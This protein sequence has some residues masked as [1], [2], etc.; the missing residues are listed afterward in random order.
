MNHIPGPALRSSLFIWDL[1]LRGHLYC[2]TSSSFLRTNAERGR[3]G[4]LIFVH[5]QQKYLQT[6]YAAS[7]SFILIFIRSLWK[8][9]PC[10]FSVSP[11]LAWSLKTSFFSHGM[12]DDT[13]WLYWKFHSGGWVTIS[14]ARIESL[15]AVW[16]TRTNNKYWSRLTIS[17][18][19]S[20]L[21]R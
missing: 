3:C 15:T 18:F 9:I 8:S 6:F 5:S 20:N 1:C 12:L 10:Y 13:R 14:F 21:K 4:C 16:F 17:N 19:L 2:K 7:V 11:P